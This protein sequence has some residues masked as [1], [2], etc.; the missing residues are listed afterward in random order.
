MELVRTYE[1]LAAPHIGIESDQIRL[2]STFGNDL[3]HADVVY[4]PIFQD[5]DHHNRPLWRLLR[6][7][8]L[9]HPKGLPPFNP[10]WTYRS[11]RPLSLAE[12]RSFPS[13]WVVVLAKRPKSRRRSMTNFQEVEEEVVRWFGHDRVVVF[14]GSLQ[15]LQGGSKR[16]ESFVPRI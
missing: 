8:H 2:L 7:R 9:L 15:I 11:H 4:Q 6:C 14:N 3:F 10:D 5:C 1:Q 12:A 13:N 16:A